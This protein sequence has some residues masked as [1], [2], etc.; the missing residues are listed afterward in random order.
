MNNAGTIKSIFP[1]YAIPGGEIAIECEGF[2]VDPEG[3]HG[4]IIDDGPCD[5]VAASSRRDK[6]SRADC[7]SGSPPSARLCP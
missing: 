5:I 4:V 3:S 6:A 7:L 1:E 2:R